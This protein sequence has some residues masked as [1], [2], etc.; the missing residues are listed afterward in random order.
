[1]QSVKTWPDRTLEEAASALSEE[2]IIE[3]SR[4]QLELMGKHHL[5]M[6]RVLA[7]FV[8]EIDGL[9]DQPQSE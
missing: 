5:E 2:A 3:A 6:R 8:A 9:G 1:M 7:A 4:E